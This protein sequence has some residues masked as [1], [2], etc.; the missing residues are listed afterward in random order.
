MIHRKRKKFLSLLQWK[1]NIC[2]K[3]LQKFRQV[4]FFRTTNE[5]MIK[6]VLLTFVTCDSGLPWTYRT[7]PGELQHIEK[8][9]SKNTSVLLELLHD[10]HNQTN[11]FTA[12]PLQ[13]DW[14]KEYFKDLM[15]S[16]CQI[17]DRKFRKLDTLYNGSPTEQQAR[18]HEQLVQFNQ[19]L[20]D[21]DFHAQQ[22]CDSWGEDIN[23]RNWPGLMQEVNNPSFYTRTKRPG[24]INQCRQAQRTIDDK[25]AYHG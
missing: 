1:F 21:G 17:P 11:D 7:G 20:L 3:N 14:S 4:A 6:W 24:L 9:I 2:H 22:I 13:G 16:K 25:V 23:M 12:E 10:E 18:C 8:F 15:I 5:S 19:D